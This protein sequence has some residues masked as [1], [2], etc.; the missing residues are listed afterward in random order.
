MLSPDKVTLF[1]DMINTFPWPRHGICHIRTD[2][3]NVQEKES[4]FTLFFFKSVFKIIGKSHY[5]GQK[6]C[7]VYLA[8]YCDRM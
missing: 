7:N 5:Q 2:I 6:G 1:Y 4:V 8:P 3:I